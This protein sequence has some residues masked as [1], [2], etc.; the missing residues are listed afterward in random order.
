[1]YTKPSGNQQCTFKQSCKNKNKTKKR[2]A[3][4]ELFNKN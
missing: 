3:S 1:M 2:S 4:G